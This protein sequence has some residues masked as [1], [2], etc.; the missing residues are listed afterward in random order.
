MKFAKDMVKIKKDLNKLGHKTAIPF[1][2]EPHLTDKDFVENLAENQKYCIENDVMRKCFEQVVSSDAVLVL[3]KKRNGINGYIGV[4]A[5]LEMGIA[6]HHGKKIFLYDKTP[7][8]D[9]ARW[10]HEVAIMQPII[11]HGDLS[12][13]H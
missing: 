7:H 13:I 10:A 3:N 11:I 12:K 8:H 6:H 1:G 2:T 4:S 9:D 5:L